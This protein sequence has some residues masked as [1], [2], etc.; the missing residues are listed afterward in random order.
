LS[1]G[2]IGKRGFAPPSSFE[3]SHDVLSRVSIDADHY[4]W[5]YSAVGPD[6]K[7]L[8]PGSNVIWDHLGRSADALNGTSWAAP[9]AAGVAAVILSETKD[10]WNRFPRDGT[11]WNEMVTILREHSTHMSL[12]TEI[13]QFGLLRR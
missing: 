7:F 6:L 13:V 5:E 8:A 11:R 1:V 4:L 3:H 9:I 2:A 12:G 10:R